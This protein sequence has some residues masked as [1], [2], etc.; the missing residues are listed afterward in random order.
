[1]GGSGAG[2]GFWTTGTSN[3]PLPFE[4]FFV[5]VPSPTPRSP[6]VGVRPVGGPT[7]SFS[8]SSSPMS[9]NLPILVSVCAGAILNRT[10]EGW[11]RKR[12]VL[13]D[14]LG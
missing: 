3:I 2:E 11:R 14:L 13:F 6:N 5:L 9:V 4:G 12:T 1:M 7:Y 8:P 10:F